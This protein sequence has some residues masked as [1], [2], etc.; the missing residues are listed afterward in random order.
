MKLKDLKTGM[1]IVDRGDREYVV[2]E[3]VVNPDG[4]RGNM[5]AMIGKIRMDARNF[6]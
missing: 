1:R 2:L 5:F 3:N 4:Q 6:I